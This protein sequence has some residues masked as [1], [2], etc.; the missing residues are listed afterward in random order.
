MVSAP[1]AYSARPPAAHDMA[2]SL[3]PYHPMK[4]PFSRECCSAREPRVNSHGILC[5]FVISGL[6][7]S[8]VREKAV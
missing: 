6:K 3:Y 5:H 1:V 4:K 8:L 7:R 2:S